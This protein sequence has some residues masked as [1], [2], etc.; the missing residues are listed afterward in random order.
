MLTYT[1][2]LMERAHKKHDFMTH[3]IGGL[4]T[5]EVEMFLNHYKELVEELNQ[6]RKSKK[7]EN[8]K[9]YHWYLSDRSFELRC[10]DAEAQ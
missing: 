6:Y 10:I 2:Y 7:P 5:S 3:I 1:N 9:L 8:K 4:S